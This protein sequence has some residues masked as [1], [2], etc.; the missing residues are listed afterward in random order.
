MKPMK[1]ISAVL[2]ATTVALAL[3][4]VAAAPAAVT[5]PFEWINTHIV[6]KASVNGSRPLSFVLDTGA[7]QAIVRLP[8]AHELGLKLT[9][10][11]SSGGAGPNR[12]SGSLV[13]GATFAVEGL[14]G[15]K[16]PISFALP[17]PNLPQGLGH[18]IDGIIGGAFI[19]E[20]VLEIDY[21]GKAITLHDKASFKYN[22]AGDVLPLQFDS[23]NHPTIAADVTPSGRAPIAGRF[24]LDIGSGLGL[25]LHTPFVRANGLPGPGEKT[26]RATGLRGA[27]GQVS[28]EIGRVAAFTIGRQRMAS[29]ITVFAQ[30]EAGALANAA[31]AGNIGNR[32]LNGFRVWFDYGRRQMILEPTPNIGAS[33]NRAFSGLSLVAEGPRYQLFRV[34]D[35]LENGPAAEAGILTGDVITSI[36]GKPATSLTLTDINDLFERVATYELTISRAD[37]TMKVKLTPAKII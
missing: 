25:A 33:A 20:F 6:L 27:G 24:T 11:V 14:A 34:S 12:N 4:T 15:G 5:I 7:D 35:V 1:A 10:S 21:Q 23:N 17:M 31:L 30:D 13:Q 36:D 19:R 37:Q 2:L 18:D 8:I 3:R 26:I 29:P 9:G 28:A 32:I 16:Y 22:G